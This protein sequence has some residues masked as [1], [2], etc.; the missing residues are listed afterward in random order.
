MQP[1]PNKNGA[2]LAEVL[3][4][5]ALFIVFSLAILAVLI[6]SAKLDRREEENTAISALGQMLLEERINQART[7]QGYQ[8]L[9]NAGLSP[10]GDPGFL[11]DAEV[12]DVSDGLKKVTVTVYFADPDSPGVRD[13]RR[14]RNGQALTLSVILGEPHP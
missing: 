13:A 4:G 10:S 7:M 1:L 8:S 2:T 9:A 3:I 14:P 5:L 12:V 6:Q 11:Y